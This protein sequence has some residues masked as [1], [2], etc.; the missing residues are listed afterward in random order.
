MLTMTNI[1]IAFAVLAAAVMAYTLT[2]LVSDLKTRKIPNWLTVS[3]LALALVF[4]TAAGAWT[5]TGALAGLGAALAGF[6]VGFGLLLVLWLIGG[7]GGGDVKL[8]G[9]LG[10]WLGPWLTLITFVLSGAIALLAVLGVFTWRFAMGKHK[11]TRKSSEEASAA[12]R[13]IPYALPASVAAWIVLLL[14]GMAVAAG[15]A[16]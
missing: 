1:Q 10:A 9:A 4:H 16:I 6:G 5:G 7:G 8:M 2:A 12:R 14:K 13:M 15:G 3:S 11:Y